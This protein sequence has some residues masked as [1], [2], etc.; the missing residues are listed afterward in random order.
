MHSILAP[1]VAAER[2]GVVSHGVC[3]TGLAVH[4]DG[5]L[6]IYD[7]MADRCIGVARVSGH[8]ALATLRA[9]TL[10]QAA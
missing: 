8:P 6:D 3:P 10:A 9:L 7:G 4:S 2:V 5:R 1:E